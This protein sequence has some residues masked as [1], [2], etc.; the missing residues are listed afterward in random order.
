MECRSPASTPPTRAGPTHPVTFSF[1]RTAAGWERSASIATTPLENVDEP[2]AAIPN[3]RSRALLTAALVA[4]PPVVPSA[5]GADTAAPI[6]RKKPTVRELHGDKFVD[7]YFW[8]REKGTPEVKAYLEAENAHTDAV[9]APYKA[10]QDTLYK[11]MLGRIKETDLSVPVRDGAYF[12][13]TR[14]EQGQQYTIYCRKK[15]SLDAPEE[16]YL[17]VNALAKGE[18]FM[19]IGT[20][21]VSDD[22]N[23]LAYT[24]DTTGFR[25]YKLYVRDLRT[26]RAA[27]AAGREGDLG[28]LGGGQQDAV[29]HD[30]RRRQAALSALSPRARRGRR[31]HD[32]LRGEGRALQRRRR[33]IAQQG[34]PVPRDR[35]PDDVRGALSGRRPAV[36]DVEDRGA[37]QGRPRVR[38]RPPR[39]SVLRPHQPGRPQL[40]AGD[41]AGE[42]SVAGAVEDDRPASRRRDAAGDAGLRGPDGAVRARQRPAAV[43]RRQGRRRG[44]G[45]VDGAAV[46]RAGVHRL[47]GRQPRVQDAD[48]PLRVPVVHDAAVGVRLR[49]RL[50]PGDAAEGNGSARRLRP[51]RSTRPS[52]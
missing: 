32:A 50:R 25:E 15:G 14:T 36:R 33:P 41:G 7:D 45:R 11:E 27:G 24:T 3:R 21:S 43:P 13:Y 17:D 2:H 38:R 4:L 22:G 48:V 9:M 18:K 34:L 6:A 12:Y 30:D 37:A 20:M 44:V 5:L 26:G 49:L 1:R 31:R 47:A 51:R 52:A 29:L 16:V 10:L 40:R 23:L 35:Q 42:R 39:R 19:A 28:R 8:L 46:P